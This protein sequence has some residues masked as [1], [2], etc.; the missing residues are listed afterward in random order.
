[1]AKV[2]TTCPFCG[3]GCG[4][5]LE[6]D[7]GKVVGTTPSTHHPINRGQLCVKGWNVH[8]FIHHPDRLQTPLLRKNGSLVPVSWDEAY[9]F[10][11]TKMKEIY[12]KS[13]PQAMAFLAS[14]KVS[15]EENYLMQKIARAI[16]KTNNVDHCARL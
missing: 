14:A 10:V 2:L 3:C 7:N 12:E 6:V 5:Y 1:M 4:M 13:G 11:V 15:N 16:F 9:N 8:E